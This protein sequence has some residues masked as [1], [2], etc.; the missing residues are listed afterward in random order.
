MNEVTYEAYIKYLD[1]RTKQ[2]SLKPIA[3]G[4]LHAHHANAELQK[5]RADYIA[6][7]K[8]QA[9]LLSLAKE[10]MD[11]L[12]A[13]NERLT[14]RVDELVGL[15]KRLREILTREVDDGRAEVDDIGIEAWIEKA[16]Q[17]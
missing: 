9:D 11:A 4:I 3:A 1:N 8:Q 5:E 13:K 12:Q 6:E 7:N 15:N 17:K 14:E 10:Q 2:E 16:L